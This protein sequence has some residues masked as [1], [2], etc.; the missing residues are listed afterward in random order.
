M[1]VKFGEI[2]CQFYLLER[3]CVVL[4]SL[5]FNTFAKNNWY[6][7]FAIMIALP[8]FVFVRTIFQVFTEES[9]LFVGD[10]FLWIS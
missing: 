3:R 9:P 8:E 10:Q 2:K 6:Q 1:I 5:W 4:N 7:G